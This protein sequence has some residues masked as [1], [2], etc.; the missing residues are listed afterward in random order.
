[1][2]KIISYDKSP[3]HRV[4]S[5]TRQPCLCRT[6]ESRNRAPAVDCVNVALLFYEYKV[7]GGRDSELLSSLRIRFKDIP[8]TLFVGDDGTQYRS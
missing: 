2:C 7:R 1:M 8:G 3:H 5:R 6:L 4:M